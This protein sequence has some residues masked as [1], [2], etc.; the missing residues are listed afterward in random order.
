[1]TAPDEEIFVDNGARKL[2][3]DELGRTQAGMGR[4]MP[5]VGARVWKLWYAA[6]ARNWPLARYEL[7]EAVSLME[8]GA[9][10]RPKYD[11]TMTQF[12]ADDL[13]PVAVAIEDA[14]WAAFETAFDR[15]VEAANRYHGVYNKGF[16]RW[17]LPDHPPP[18]LDLTPPR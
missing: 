10:V 1:M 15:M 6:E 18:D 8:L 13:A 2:S 17:R 11:R 7:E 4:L 9:F 5:E 3:L 16:I 14:D 12:L